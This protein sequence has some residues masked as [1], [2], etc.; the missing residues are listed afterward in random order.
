MKEI[1]L[2]NDLKWI[3]DELRRETTQD[4]T[5][6]Q[7]ESGEPMR[8][9]TSGKYEILKGRVTVDE[10]TWRMMQAIERRVYNATHQGQRIN[11]AVKS[12]FLAV[13]ELENGRSIY[14][15]DIVLQIV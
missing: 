7:T 8:R 1:E 15:V 11:I 14:K 10:S 5:E 13:Q 6:T 9:A 2:P 4:F 12:A 3:I